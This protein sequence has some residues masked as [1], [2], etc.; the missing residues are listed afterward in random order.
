MEDRDEIKELFSQKLKEHQVSVRPEIWNNIQSQLG[1]LGTGTT[2]AS[3]V[4]GKSLL[5]KGVASVVA[6]TGLSIGGYFYFNSPSQVKTKI[7]QKEV[8][9]TPISSSKTKVP[10]KSVGVPKNTKQYANIESDFIEPDVEED[11][12][13]ATTDKSAKGS[14]SSYHLPKIVEG[15]T[16]SAT[17]STITPLVNP[18]TE[19][20]TKSILLSSENQK[21]QKEE[22]ESSTVKDI[23]ANSN[24]TEQVFVST[25]SPTGSESNDIGQIQEWMATNVFTPNGDGVNDYFFLETKNLSEFSISILNKNNQVVYR[26]EDSNFHWDGRNI[27]TNEMVAEG[28][29]FYIVVAKDKAGKSIQ[30]YQVLQIA[31]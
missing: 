8:I 23:Q 7:H 27:H 11:N 24:K 21:D 10:D 9:S 30:H 5:F 12:S 31:R 6:V 13:L 15:E 4:I 17:Q 20:N 22:N 3:S 29:Y 2:V 28:T 19:T 14:N 26:S 18:K 25:K 16:L 1:N